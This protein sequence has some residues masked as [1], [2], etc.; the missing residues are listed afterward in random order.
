[1][2]LDRSSGD[3]LSR[4]KMFPK[5][6]PESNPVLAENQ[7][8]CLNIMIITILKIIFIHQHDHNHVNGHHVKV[9]VYDRESP[10]SG[11]ASSIEQPTENVFFEIVK[12]LKQ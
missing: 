2:R 12:V 3:S 8:L 11:K 5:K 10:G 9:P 7:I 6:Y 1:M 4:F